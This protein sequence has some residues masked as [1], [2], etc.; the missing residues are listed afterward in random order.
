MLPQNTNPK[1][2]HYHNARRWYEIPLF[3]ITGASYTGA[4]WAIFPSIF[5]IIA[6]VVS[7]FAL[8]WYF[9][10]VVKTSYKIYGNH[11]EFFNEYNPENKEIILLDDIFQVRY[12]DEFGTGF[13]TKE[14]FI[15]A[16]LKKGHTTISKKVKKDRV[17]LYVKS[18]EKVRDLIHILS[19]F[20]KEGKEV[21]ILTKYKAINQALGLKN[22]N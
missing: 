3:L 6:C 19:F 7:V 13:E 22:W 11:I 4:V 14:W 10:T 12:E 15:Y 16:Y 21:Y 1:L 2:I 20:Q 9:F 18:E 17:K 5:T 8:M